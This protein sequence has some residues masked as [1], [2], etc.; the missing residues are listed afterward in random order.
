MKDE[1]KRQENSDENFSS[2]SSKGEI[3]PTGKGDLEYVKLVKISRNQFEDPPDYYSTAKR[4]HSGHFR[5][6]TAKVWDPHPQYEFTAFGRHFHLLLSHDSSFVFPDMKVTHVKNN[7]TKWEHA[8]QHLDCF[9]SGIVDGDPNSIVAVNLCG[10][11]TGHM[12]T[13]T[14]SYL[15]K[16]AK[17]WSD[18]EDG[19]MDPPLQHAIYRI[20]SS[21]ST[22]TNDLPS[23]H[24]CGVID[25]TESDPTVPFDD[26]SERK[27]YVGDQHRRRKRRLL[28]KN[29]SLDDFQNEDTPRNQSRYD[30]MGRE[31]TYPSENDSHLSYQSVEADFD[32]YGGWRTRRALPREYFIEIMVVADSKMMEYHGD[33]LV[34]YILVLMNMVS[35][36]YKDPSIGNPISIAVV[37]IIN[38]DEIFGTKNREADGISAE[39]MLKK[40]CYWQKRNNPHEPSP[41]HYDAALLLTRENLCHNPVAKRCDTLGLAELGRMC[42]PGSSCAIV[43]DNGLAAAFTI[44]HEI[45]HVLNM[46][47]DDDTKCLRFR[48]PTKMHNI[49]SRMLDDNT[50]PW[51]WSKCSRHYSTEFLDA[52]YAQCLLDE[53]SKAIS[54]SS[55]GRLPGEEFTENEQCELIFGP[56][57][58]ICPHMISDVCKRLWC[59]APLYDKTQQCHTQHMPWA[60]GTTCGDNKWCHRGECVSRQNLLPVDGQWGTWGRYGDCS[61]TCGGGIKKKYRECNNPPPQNG[62]NYCIGERVKYRN[63]GTKECSAGSP[64]F[65]E[66]QCAAFND[67]NLNIRNLDRNVKWHAKYTKI[68]PEDRC[69]LFCQ[70]ES[71]QYYMLRDKVIDGTPCGPD[72]FDMC[73]NGRC[74]P[75]G[76]D[77][78]LNSSAEMDTCGVC[79]G[80]DSTCQRITG[81]FNSSAYGYTKVTKI[82]AGSSFI[83]IRQHGW[84]GLHNDSNY[85]VLRL[86]ESE[87]YILNGNFMVMH[88][89]VIVRPGMAIEYNGPESV[90]ERL[91][92]SRPINVDLILEILSVGNVS[93]PQITYEY[94]VPKKILE[95]YT[96]I[97]SN[98]S[99]CSLS[100]Q[101]TK[102][103][104]G[105]CRGTEHKDVVSNDYCRAEEIP[106]E[107]SQICNNH[108]VLQWQI[109]SR[110]ECSS[111][112]GPGTRSV[113]SRCVQIVHSFDNRQPGTVS[114]YVCSHLERPK[115]QEP[116]TGSCHDVRWNYGE[117]AACSVTCG[118]G[119][120][121][122]SASC[123]DSKGRPVS[124]EKCASQEKIVTQICGQETCPKWDFGDWTPC[125][126]TCGIGKR[127]RPYWCQV[128]NRV[129]HANYCSG[130]PTAFTEI[131]DAGPCYQWHSGEWSLCSVTCGDGTRRRE[132]TCRDGKDLITNKTNCDSTKQPTDTSGCMLTLCP[133]MQTL[134]SVTSTLNSPLDEPSQQE[135][136]VNTNRISPRRVFKWHSEG[137]DVVPKRIPCNIQ[138]CPVWNTGDWSQCDVECGEGYQYRQVRCQSSRGTILPDKECSIRQRPRHVRKCEKST[139]GPSVHNSFHRWRT[140]N[141]SACSA[142][143]GEGVQ[144][145]NVTCHRVNSFGLLDPNPIEGCPTVDKPPEQQ[146]CK[147]SECINEHY[148][149]TGNWKKCSHACGRKGRQVRRL[150]CH[151]KT[152][153]K[154]PRY[155]CP[156]ELKPQRKR[157]C[158]Q[159]R[160]GPSSCLEIQRR[161]K[162]T[163]DGEYTLVIGGRNM[164]IYCHG[165]GSREPKEYLTLPAGEKENFAEIYDKRLHN[166]KTCPFNGQRNDS[167]HCVT[168]PGTISG[169]TK[170]KRIRIDPN[171]QY[172]I[173]DDYTFSWNEGSKR[174][175]FGKA[176]DCYSLAN[177]PQGRFSI[178]L[179]GT[180]F[181]LSPQ[182]SWT[183]QKSRAFL[184][185]NRVND[186]M[187]S[188]KCGGYCGFCTPMAG[189]KLD[190][191][192]P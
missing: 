41:E 137:A 124:D 24:E 121:R 142:G 74:K 128:E 5:H 192:P 136:D 96:W 129:V 89:K 164:S 168:D 106:R 64:D 22:L 92:S 135:N 19:S 50:F 68:L 190:I 33:G 20:S 125:S 99:E 166:P 126:V 73:V 59:T 120:Q 177:C 185:I 119:M 42:S 111:H 133:T 34:S 36:I 47:H 144:R 11:M 94:T 109:T 26:S 3:V 16:P 171:T 175:E 158:N 153:K 93:P 115:E 84:R 17:R 86:A 51:E 61:R 15:I 186:Q 44:A 52:G 62:G 110:S 130:S 27:V 97:L 4:H 43:Q 155:N 159:R 18:D 82:P 131:C 65:R 154:V 167:C 163:R 21:D 101:G 85:L 13:S 160:C 49:M 57:S 141:W 114:D 7:T 113:T 103:R 122:R 162:S 45:G 145:R 134:P 189:L 6:K 70:V 31:R 48:N 161:L 95:R 187:I 104:R 87:E 157:K 105:E 2:G 53:P 116:C 63:C 1:S 184:K 10:G 91:N 29:T 123:I 77:H 12:T 169:I 191:L 140:S 30:S 90:V 23:N 176:G 54:K 46:P 170:F 98:W 55:T 78:I 112:C 40:F 188:G 149:T 66:E 174:V 35:R 72:T 138:P 88:K 37:K 25:Y 56:G 76:C 182:V 108:C 67:N 80:D 69:K 147:I 83:D 117:W 127:Q 151:N 39:E 181:K 152:G 139:C 71:N 173:A 14:G 172:I 178:N 150:F 32:N 58:K 183:T 148:W 118:G 107:E 60:D 143:C 165:M 75:A 28:W 180:F 8:G 146:P 132:V 179:S 81:S 102:Y 79:R 100:C 38:T 156:A 9:Y